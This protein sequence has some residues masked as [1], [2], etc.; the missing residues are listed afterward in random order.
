M[1]IWVVRHLS[2]GGAGLR[3]WFGVKGDSSGLDGGCLRALWRGVAV[4]YPRTRESVF[5]NQAAVVNSTLRV[6]L[7]LED[8]SRISRETRFPSAS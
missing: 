2:F 7:T 5:P 6:S 4:L 8:A 1:S 3:E